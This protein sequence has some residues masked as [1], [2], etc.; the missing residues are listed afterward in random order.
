MKWNPLKLSGTY[1]GDIL[2]TS[3]I[4]P[5]HYKEEIAELPFEPPKLGDGKYQL[6][7]GIR[8]VMKLTR[9]E[10]L[11]WGLRKL[12]FWNSK[13]LSTPLVEIECGGMTIT[14]PQIPNVKANPNFPVSSTYFDILLPEGWTYKP[15]INI[16]LMDKRDNGFIPLVGKY[17]L[18]EFAK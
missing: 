15:P 18:T 12:K 10:I 8:P 7:P 16:R 4:F 5:A 14:L 9:V 13:P 1:A 17:V 6:P 2:G 11:S 3:Q